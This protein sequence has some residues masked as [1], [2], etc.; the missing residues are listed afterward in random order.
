M[1]NKTDTTDI[2]Q[3]LATRRTSRRTLLA[4]AGLAGIGALGANSLTAS[5]QQRSKGRT[6]NRG[7]PDADIL[8]FALNLEYLEAEYYLYSAF[9]NGLNEMDT[10]GTGTRGIVIGGNEDSASTTFRP[11]AVPFATQSFRE[12]AEEIARDEEAHVKFLRS[13]LG[14]GAVA[15]PTIDIT[16]SFTKAAVA[17]GVIQQ[18][19]TFDPYAN[20]NNFLLGA[21]IFEDVGVTAYKGAA[22]LINNPAILEAAAG[23]LAVEAYH[24]SEVR[25]LLFARGRMNPELQLIET[26]QR[27]SDLRDTADNV[28]GISDDRDQGVVDANGRANIVPTDANALAYSRTVA[29]VLNIVYL[30][31]ESAGFGFFPNR[32]NG[33]IR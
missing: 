29:Q 5:A 28:D 30:G 16:T 4:T 17:A 12:Y 9:G 23:L 19:E 32:L 15:R 6:F 8:N 31:G 18:G 24:A 7:V 10:F 1:S 27:I 22:P 26:V 11:R 25:T 13:A 14:L 21:F 33:N 2:L 20:E 3:E